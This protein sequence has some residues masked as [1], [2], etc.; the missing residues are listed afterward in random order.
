MWW[1]WGMGRE[2]GGKEK[3]KSKRICR[4][5]QNIRM[6]H[7][8][9]ESL[10]SEPFPSLGVRAHLTS[11]GCPRHCADLWTC[12]GGSSE[13]DLVLLLCVPASSVHSY[14]NECVFLCGGSQ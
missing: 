8:F 6:I 2:G 4:T 10:L 13:S 9:L 3:K 7:A 11:L 14:Q 1:A 5:S 12:C